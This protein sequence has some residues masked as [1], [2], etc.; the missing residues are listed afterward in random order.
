M[1]GGRSLEKIWSTIFV[2]FVIIA[3][4]ISIPQDLANIT[5]IKTL[6][7]CGYTLML[8]G[9]RAVVNGKIIPE[10]DFLMFHNNGLDLLNITWRTEK[11]DGFTRKDLFIATSES[12]VKGCGVLEF[13]VQGD[14]IVNFK[15][16]WQNRDAVLGAFEMP[17][18]TEAPDFKS[19]EEQTSETQPTRYLLRSDAVIGTVSPNILIY[20]RDMAN[21]AGYECPNPSAQTY[22]VYNPVRFT[23]LLQKLAEAEYRYGF[24]ISASDQ[25]LLWQAKKYLG[26]SCPT[27]NPAAIGRI[28]LVAGRITFKSY[29]GNWSVRGF[30]ISYPE[31]YSPKTDGARALILEVKDTLASETFEVVHY[32]VFKMP[33]TMDDI[34]IMASILKTTADTNAWV[35]TGFL[36]WHNLL[37]RASSYLTFGTMDLPMP[38]ITESTVNAFG[39]WNSII[40]A[41]K[42]PQGIPTAQPSSMAYKIPAKL[43]AGILIYA[44]EDCFDDDEFPWAT[45]DGYLY[46]S[47]VKNGTIHRVLVPMYVSIKYGKPER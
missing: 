19:T 21:L 32:A 41:W 27:G 46:I 34:A 36:A 14:K 29:G 22:R 44:T 5:P 11:K 45:Y 3:N 2:A 10:E 26:G 17:K 24:D 37:S 39:G 25:I 35:N 31:D 1:S 6:R 13:T 12:G 42:S 33:T 47:S 40:R 43:T 9:R 8:S 23:P 4:L 16:K 18:P 28:Q 15:Q 7:A 20:D 30:N 38:H